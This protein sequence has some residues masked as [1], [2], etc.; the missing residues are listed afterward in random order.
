MSTLW[1]DDAEAICGDYACYRGRTGGWN[2]QYKDGP[3]QSKDCR[4]PKE[5]GTRPHFTDNPSQP[6]RDAGKEALKEKNAK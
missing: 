4:W 3:C 2:Y 6:V 1:G 5:A